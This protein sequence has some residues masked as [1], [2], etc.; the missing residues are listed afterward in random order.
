MSEEELGIRSF[1]VQIIGIIVTMLLTVK[2]RRREKT[3]IFGISATVMF[4]DNFIAQ[5]LIMGGG[6]SFTVG[7]VL[8]PILGIIVSAITLGICKI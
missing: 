1:V 2:Y 7:L 5:Q 3:T 8:S 4:I 6:P